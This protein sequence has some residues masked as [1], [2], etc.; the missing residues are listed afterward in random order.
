[1][2]QNELEIELFPSINFIT[3]IRY[4]RRIDGKFYDISSHYFIDRAIREN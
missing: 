1:M 4:V 3:I 2:E